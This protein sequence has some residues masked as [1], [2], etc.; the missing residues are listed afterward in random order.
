[1]LCSVNSLDV[2][3]EAEIYLFLCFQSSFNYS[4]KD[5]NCF[6][7]FFS[8]YKATSFLCYFWFDFVSLAK[9]AVI[10]PFG[11]WELLCLPF[12]LK[13]FVQLFQRLMDGIRQDLSFAFVYKYLKDILVAS[14]SPQEH[15][16]HLQQLS[17]F[18][19]LM[20]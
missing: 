5:V 6:F 14:H 4:L 16:Q 12:G 11:L 8:L 1:M 7:C 3:I 13:N 9:T 10:T 20:G 17:P 19:R 2:V 15:S 18:F